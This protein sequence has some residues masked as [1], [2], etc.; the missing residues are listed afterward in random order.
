MTCHYTGGLLVCED[1]AASPTADSLGDG[2]IL[3]SVY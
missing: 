3:M 1:L 2:L